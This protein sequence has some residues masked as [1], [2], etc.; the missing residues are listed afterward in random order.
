MHTS[1][2]GELPTS[3]GNSICLD[4]S[5]LWGLK[6]ESLE[7]WG[8]ALGGCTDTNPTGLTVFPA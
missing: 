8:F 2:N 1:P 5:R 4:H 7:L 3:R 6:T